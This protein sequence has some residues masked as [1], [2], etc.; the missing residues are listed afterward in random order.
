MALA[1]EVLWLRVLEFPTALGHAEVIHPSRRIQGHMSFTH[2]FLGLSASDVSE[3]LTVDLA[4]ESQRKAFRNLASGEAILPERLL[5]NGAEDSVSFCYAARLDATA[6]AVCKFGSVNPGNGN[7]GLPTISAL[8]TVLDELTGLPV[9]IM[10]GTSVTTI[11]TSAASAVAVEALARPGSNRLAVIGSGVQAAAH[12]RA[13]ARVLELTDVAVWSR[14]RSACEA[15]VRTLNAEYDFT[16]VAAA[17]AAAAVHDA[18]VITTCTSSIDP[19]LESDWVKDG[20][21][22]ISVGSFA[23]DRCEIPQDLVAR[24]DA[25]VVDHAETAMEHA[26]P[27]VRALAT[28]T[29]E[30]ADLIE[31]GDVLIGRKVARTNADQVIYYNS[32]GIGI[33]DAAAAQAVLAAARIT[34]QGQRI[35]L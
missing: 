25:V 7:R 24:A 4:I 22:V 26:G 35:S 30:A 15:L 32:V 20:A 21:T 34:G 3:L 2:E 16:V 6:G 9:A 28:G 8:V 1:L 10:D 33:Q 13:I 18:D 29:L 19:V 23:P 31:L 17:S 11:R 27:I 14:D 12:V 5:L